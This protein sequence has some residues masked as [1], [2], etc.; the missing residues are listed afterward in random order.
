MVPYR[1]N[2]LL[3]LAA[4]MLVVSPILAGQKPQ[5]L[6]QAKSTGAFDAPIKKVSVDLGPSPYTPDNPEI[7]NTL[8]CFYFPHL[9]IKEYDQGQVG[10]EWLSILRRRGKLPECK[11]SHQPG[12]RVIDGSEWEGN[13]KGVK[14]NLVFFDGGEV[15]FSALSFAVFDLT[16]GK[17]LFED[18]AYVS[19]KA[20]R[21]N[22]RTFSTKAGVTVKYLRAYYTDC[23]LHSSEKEA[24]WKKVKAKLGLK[25]EEIPVCTGYD[26][27]AKLV[28]TDQ[29]ESWIAYPVEVNLSPHPVVRTVAGPTKCWP[30]H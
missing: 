29:V 30:T 6:S 9:L 7:R 28:G 25:S 17:K 3:S 24:C 23:N 4:A 15:Q 21:P 1:R 13:F 18:D 26:T 27:I 2:V 5:Q 22:L 11:L 16:T 19:Q 12:E 10:A 14:G 8:S 20:G